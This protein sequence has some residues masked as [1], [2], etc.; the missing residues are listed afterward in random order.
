MVGG[1]GIV[2][3][4]DRQSSARRVSPDE[5]LA[6]TCAG[7]RRTARAKRRPAAIERCELLPA[8][9][10]VRL[11]LIR[12]R[13]RDARSC[14]LAHGPSTRARTS[15]EDSR[16]DP[17][18]QLRH[19]HGLRPD[20]EIDAVEERTRDGRDARDCAACSGTR[21]A[22]RRGSRRGTG[23]S[24]DEHEPARGSHGAAARAI[25]TRPSSSGWRSA[26]S[27]CGTNP[28]THRETARRDARGSPRPAG[29][30]C[31]RRP[32]PRPRWCGAARGTAD[33]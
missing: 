7:A 26:S 14:R 31:R 10:P 29:A 30:S 21:V 24:R 22:D 11:A 18:A 32:A 8:S 27:T 4:R 25:V 2:D 13:G 16:A 9:V 3:R 20:V 33:R 23:S 6:P 1:D 19:R 5:T 28:A 12:A 17:S 15:A